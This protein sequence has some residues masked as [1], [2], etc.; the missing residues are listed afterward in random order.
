MSLNI[1]FPDKDE[2]LGNLLEVA[3]AYTLQVLGGVSAEMISGDT[4]ASC[5]FE[6]AVILHARHAFETGGTMVNGSMRE[7]PQGYWALVNS[8]F[9]PE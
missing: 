2:E 1:D 7:N 4:A 5:I 9:I 6:Q 3:E 8:I